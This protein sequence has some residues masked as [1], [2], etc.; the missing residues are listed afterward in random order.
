MAVGVIIITFWSLISTNNPALSK[1]Q[2][3]S[4]LRLG[5]N[6]AQTRQHYEELHIELQTGAELWSE[7]I[8]SR[9]ENYSF[10]SYLL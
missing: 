4:K 5:C 6:Q 8:W 3:L 9:E 10:L 1:S 2:V 7:A